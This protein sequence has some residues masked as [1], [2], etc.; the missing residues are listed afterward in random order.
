MIAQ[1]SAEFEEAPKGRRI[2]IGIQ[3]G[4]FCEQVLVESSVCPTNLLS[5]W[6]LTLHDDDAEVRQAAV[7]GLYYCTPTAACDFSDQ[8]RRIAD[9]KETCPQR[10]REAWVVLARLG[11]Q[12][13]L[14]WLAKQLSHDDLATREQA[15]RELPNVDGKKL[16]RYANTRNA[17]TDD[18]DLVRVTVARMLWDSESNVTDTIPILVGVLTNRSSEQRLDAARLLCRMKQL[19]RVALPSLIALRDEAEWTLRLQAVRAVRM[20]AKGDEFALDVLT[21]LS[22]DTNQFVARE[23]REGIHDFTGG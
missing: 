9:E 11:E 10:Q 21:A 19:A 1:A 8:V 23:A 6:Q 20:I 13:G 12:D 17:L 3:C 5:L 7:S 16:A 18:S 14:H 2:S 15:A 4:V 22:K